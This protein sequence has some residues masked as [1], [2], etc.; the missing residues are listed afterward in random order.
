[1]GKEKA[2]ENSQNQGEHEP[3]DTQFEKVQKLGHIGV[4]PV[5]GKAAFEP[6]SPQI[7]TDETPTNELDIVRP[8]D[9]IHEIQAPNKQPSVDTVRLYDSQDGLPDNPNIIPGDE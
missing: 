4:S 9:T 6:L 8:D 2:P 1:M 7:P 5:T 3:S